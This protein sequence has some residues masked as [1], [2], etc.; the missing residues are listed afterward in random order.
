MIAYQ[1]CTL[2]FSCRCRPYGVVLSD[3]FLLV[4]NPLK[5][6]K[7]TLNHTFI[8]HDF[9]TVATLQAPLDPH[10]SSFKKKGSETI[11]GLIWNCCRWFFSITVVKTVKSLHLLVWRNIKTYSSLSLSPY[12]L[13]FHCVALKQASYMFHEICHVLPCFHWGRDGEAMPL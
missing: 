5:E 4:L 10:Y 13:D 2:T 9:G 11:Q 8:A 3:C 6:R 7:K 1:W 12:C